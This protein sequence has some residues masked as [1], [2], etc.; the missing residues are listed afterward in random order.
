MIDNTEMFEKKLQTPHIALGVLD[1][2]DI[3]EK[4][5][6]VLYAWQANRDAKNIDARLSEF[7]NEKD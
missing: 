5:K 2:K 7:L 4:Q 6:T 1:L 3:A